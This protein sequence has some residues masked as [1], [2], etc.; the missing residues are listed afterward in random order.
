MLEDFHFIRPLWFVGFLPLGVIVF[1]L[2]RQRGG[3]N[4]WESVCDAHLLP[5]LLSGSNRA[6]SRVPY[7][8]LA[9][10][11]SLCLLALAGPVWSK[12]PQPVF[13]A[14]SALVLVLDL[15]RSMDVEDIQPSRLAR[16]KHKVLDIL[17]RRQEGQ[18]ALVVFS[19]EPYVVSPLTEDANTIAAM[20]ASLDTNL[21]PAQGSRPDLALIQAEKL[22]EQSDV[23]KG[24]I[25]LITD[26]VEAGDMDGVVKKLRHAGHHVSVLGVGTTDGAPIPQSNGFVKDGDGS[27]VI[28]KLDPQRLADLAR[29]GHGRYATLT[30]D[31]QD[32]ETVLP[33][34]WEISD[35]K[36]DGTAQRSTEL[37]REE[38]PWIL[39]G[40]VALAIPAFRPGWLG[41]LALMLLFAPSQSDAF[42]GEDWWQRPD[43][44]GARALEQDDPHTAATLFEDSSWKG[45]AHYRAGNYQEAVE[46]FSQDLTADGHFNRGNALARTG[47][48]QEALDAYQTALQQTSTHEDAQHNYELIEKLLQQQENQRNSQSED[49]SSQDSQSGKSEKSDGQET[50]NGGEQQ[51]QEGSSQESHAGKQSDPS[52]DQSAGQSSQDLD[53]QEQ[54]T[55]GSPEEQQQEKK[56]LAQPDQSDAD[57][58]ENEHEGQEAGRLSQNPEEQPTD[59]TSDQHNM[60]SAGL[61]KKEKVELE[62]QQ[63]MQQWLRRIPDDPGGLLRR[64]FLF[65]HQRRQESGQY[66]QS[67]GQA[68]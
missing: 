46:Q 41:L 57:Q 13:R 44:Q 14:Q 4:S 30:V 42:F 21:M 25:L 52:S 51:Q 50:Q 40:I 8:L 27:I 60:T 12:L 23:P 18:T 59:D 68:W 2:V 24:N 37:W 64:K 34:E 5:H 29:N 7:I 31:D 11:W 65:E 54:S 39:L 32:L 28:P 66:N 63:A 22:L 47:K 3:S 26:G 45:V 67:G 17:K 20:V 48:L 53:Q 6:Q 49:D 55:V 33:E 19:A 43:Q 16:A 35:N 58:G 61:S 38:G 36:Q 1:L 9:T 62:S 10:V 56:D 15:S